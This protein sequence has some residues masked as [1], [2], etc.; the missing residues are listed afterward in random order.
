MKASPEQLDNAKDGSFLFRQFTLPYFDAPYHFHPEFELTLILKSEGKRFVGNQ[1]A[2]FQE[3]DLVLLGPNVPHCWKND[4]IGVE[5]SARSIVVQF[6]DDFLGEAFFKNPE[7]QPVKMLLE[8]AKA[9]IH[10]TGKTR[11]RV[12]REMIF[13]LTVPPFQKLLGLLDLLN[14]V[15]ISKDYEIIDSHSEKYDLSPIDLDRINKVYAYVIEHY[16]QEVHLETAAHLAN[17]TETAFCRYFK[18]ITQKTFLDLVTEFRIKHACNLLTST[19]KQV[20]EVCF[21]SGFGNISHFNKQFKVVT[22]YSPLHYRKMFLA[23]I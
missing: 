20:A 23:T 1:V 22:G 4:G 21:E 13:L 16:T 3:G 19:D 6:K 18:K 14:T 11:D 15:A 9:G 2:D 12:A 7:T 10:I 17:M 5:N 8:K